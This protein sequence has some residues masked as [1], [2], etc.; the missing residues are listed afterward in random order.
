MSTKTIERDFAATLDSF[1]QNLN[2][3]KNLLCDDKHNQKLV[4]EQ[5]VLL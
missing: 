5:V 2:Y 3:K 1:N 4:K